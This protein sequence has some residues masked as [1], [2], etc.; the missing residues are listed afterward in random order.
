MEGGEQKTIWGAGLEAAFKRSRIDRFRKPS[1]VT[2]RHRPF[3]QR[4]A[5]QG[6]DRRRCGSGNMERPAVATN[7]HRRAGDERRKS[8]SAPSKVAG[9]GKA[10]SSAGECRSRVIK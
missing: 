8:S 2:P 10:L 3:G 7:V 4:R 6:D 5:E 1:P 9:I